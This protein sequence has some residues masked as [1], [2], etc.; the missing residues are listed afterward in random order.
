VLNRKKLFAL[1]FWLFAILPGHAFSVYAGDG[2]PL[3]L[4]R[5]SILIWK[6]QNTTLDTIFVVRIAEFSPSRYLEWEDERTQGTIFMPE[7]DVLA[8]KGYVNSNLFQAGVDTRSK[9]TT[10]LWL[11]RKIYRD[12]KERKTIKCDL[13]GVSG[14]LTYLGEDQLTVDINGNPIALRVI[15]VSDDRGSERWFLDEEQN[16]LMMKHMIR[17]FS[18]T[19]TS[20]TTNKSNT[21]RWIKGNKLQNLPH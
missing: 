7:Q 13:D 11:S 9:N 12:L 10:T 14:Q 21:L 5:D 15:K 1:S 18:Q 20:I 2:S 3:L 6:I 19:L 4:G 17:T 8:A 16:P